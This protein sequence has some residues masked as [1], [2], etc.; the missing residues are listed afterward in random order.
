MCR[1]AEPGSEFALKQE[2]QSFG[3]ARFG[4]ARV[5]GRAQDYSLF[6]IYYLYMNQL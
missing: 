2:A 3:S 4:S 1:T 6:I 5:S